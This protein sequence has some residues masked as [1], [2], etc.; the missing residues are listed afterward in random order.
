ML[1][2]LSWDLITQL[3]YRWIKKQRTQRHPYGWELRVMVWLAGGSKD[4]VMGVSTTGGGGGAL[5]L[6]FVGT[7]SNKPN[8]RHGLWSTGGGGIRSVLPLLPLAFLAQRGRWDAGE[9]NEPYPP[10]NRTRGDLKWSVYTGA[11]V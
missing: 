2:R 5:P 4:I 7:Q 9:F 6:G 10:H 11:C 8:Q 1:S 3:H